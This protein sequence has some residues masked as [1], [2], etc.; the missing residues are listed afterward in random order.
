MS[1]AL[2]N[3]LREGFAVTGV[4]HGFPE[5][6]RR[7]RWVMSI[8]AAVSLRIGLLAD[9][10][11]AADQTLTHNGNG[12]W[13]NPNAWTPV[14]VPN[15]GATTYDAVFH[16]QYVGFGVETLTLGLN[17]TI[18]RFSMTGGFLAG[19]DGGTPFILTLNDALNWSGGI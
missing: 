17:P 16:G 14:G 19:P 1:A 9:F 4:A 7:A 10:A 15:N 6:R 3:K 5:H 2:S 13:A 12:D 18:E 8:A 11:P